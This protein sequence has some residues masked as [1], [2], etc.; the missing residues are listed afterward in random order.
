MPRKF[1]RFAIACKAVP[2]AHEKLAQAIEKKAADESDKKTKRAFIL[3]LKYRN[4]AAKHHGKFAEKIAKFDRQIKDDNIIRSAANAKKFLSTTAEDKI[5]IRRKSLA[6]FTNEIGVDVKKTKAFNTKWQNNIS[7][8]IS[9]LYK[10]YPAPIL[11]DFGEPEHETDWTIHE[12]PYDGWQYGVHPWGHG[13]SSRVNHVVDENSGFVRNELWLDNPSAGDYDWGSI[14]QDTQL[15][16]LHTAKASGP[17][18]IRVHG[19]VNQASVEYVTVDEFGWSDSVTSFNHA[20]MAHVIHPNTDAVLIANMGETRLESDETQRKNYQTLPNFANISV[21]LKTTGSI[22]KGE[23]VE[24]RFGCRSTL[25]A[26]SNDVEMHHYANH[27]WR[28]FRV[29]IRS[30]LP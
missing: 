18:E 16:V 15:V 26:A 5:D 23:T 7:D 29:E 2:T 3:Q 17:L 19:Q 8:L 25:A 27:A 12:P 28:F 30:L 14:E 24:V 4:E 9:D 10:D 13:F 21:I 1:S 11:W 20:I 6:E 22:P